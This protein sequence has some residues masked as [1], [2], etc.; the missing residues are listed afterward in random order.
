LWEADS[1]AAFQRYIHNITR[2][3]PSSCHEAVS[4]LLAED[5]TS[6]KK[7]SFGRLD[8]S[9]LFFINGGAFFSSKT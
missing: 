9:D 2:S 8:T 7:E 5:W 4:G 3:Y 1:S 6:S